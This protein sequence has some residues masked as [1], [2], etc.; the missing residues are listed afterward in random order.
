MTAVSLATQNG[1]IRR[2]IIDLPGKLC[3]HGGIA[4]WRLIYFI[5]EP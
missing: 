4:K 3:C 1:I 2:A 5:R